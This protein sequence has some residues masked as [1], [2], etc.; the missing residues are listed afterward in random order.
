VISPQS[1][2]ETG[3]SGNGSFKDESSSKLYEEDDRAESIEKQNT[4][5]I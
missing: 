2:F 1:F 5:S 4:S 3:I